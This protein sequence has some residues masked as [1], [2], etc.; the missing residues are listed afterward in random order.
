MPALLIAVAVGGIVGYSIH[1]STSDILAGLGG[2]A[3][4]AIVAG[5]GVAVYIN[6]HK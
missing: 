2:F 5:V 1:N 3:V 6:L 4:G